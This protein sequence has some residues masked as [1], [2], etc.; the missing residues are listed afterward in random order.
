MS[1]PVTVSPDTLT[2][3][4]VV[5]G[6]LILELLVLIVFLVR[7]AWWLSR[8]FTLID[9]AFAASAREIA[10]VK[11]DVSNDIAGRKVVA[12]A[13]TDIALIKAAVAEFRERLDRIEAAQDA[14]RQ[15]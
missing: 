12:E 11:A 6:G 3:T 2:L 1:A 15:A 5:A 9:A 13:R 14:R 7:V 8:R 10:G 4:W